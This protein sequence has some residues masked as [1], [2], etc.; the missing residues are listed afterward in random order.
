MRRRIFCFSLSALIGEGME[1]E[2]S[3]CKIHAEMGVCG[4]R[5]DEKR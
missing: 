5:V 1:A 4:V 2:M 3:H